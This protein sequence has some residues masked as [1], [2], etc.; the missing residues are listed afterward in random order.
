MLNECYI[1]PLGD[2]VVAVVLSIAVVETVARPAHCTL[3]DAANA[4]AGY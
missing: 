4:Q 3:L 2:N 1:V